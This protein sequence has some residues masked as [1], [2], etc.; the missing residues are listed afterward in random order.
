M[1]N[2]SNN[3]LIN[4]A[5]NDKNGR[6][7]TPRRPWS[8]WS[9][10]PERVK[11]LARAGNERFEARDEVQVASLPVSEAVYASFRAGFGLD[12]L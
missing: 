2:I 7:S 11:G 9:W 6:W 12:E 3:N 5:L 4:R 1:M 10:C 8:W